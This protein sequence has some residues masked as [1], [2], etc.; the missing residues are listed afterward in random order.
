MA[1]LGAIGRDGFS[2][3]I[4]YGGGF[5]GIVKDAAGAFTQRIVR[6]YHR[7]SGDYSGGAVSSPVDGTYALYTNIL[8]GKTEH[9]LVELDDE[10]GADYNDRALGR[11]IPF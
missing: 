3:K 8:K 4:L 7:E 1:D 11:M 2:S 5:T 10:T 9:T 6:A